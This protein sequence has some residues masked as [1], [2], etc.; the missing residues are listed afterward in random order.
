[1]SRIDY[2][3]MLGRLYRARRGGIEFLDVPAMRFLMIDGQGRPGT[4]AAYTR[5][6]EA[7]YPV[8]Y[9]LKFMV[10]R[11]TPAEDFVV[12]PL[13]GLW[14]ADDMDD[15]VTGN[16]DRWRWTLMIMQPAPVSPELFSE[17]VAEVG[18]KKA[19]PALTA[20]RFETFAEG[21][22]AQT[23]HVGPYD[24]EG[25]AIRALH[26]AIAERQ[27]KLG[28]KHHEIYLGDVRRAAPEKLR[29]ILRQ[30]YSS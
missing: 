30:P 5:A 4:S 17:A 9:T 23:L 3:K 2:R 27:F 16:K 8:A 12:M 7:L 14:W 24:A 21:S 28:G 29:T 22:C 18:R 15:F 26:A 13:E 25:P 10:K 20:V 11:R 19:P 1:M 6:V